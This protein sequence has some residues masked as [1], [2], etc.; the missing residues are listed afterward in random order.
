[1]KY[2]KTFD[3]R[4]VGAAMAFCVALAQPVRASGLNPTAEAAQKI[5]ASRQD[6]VLWITATCKV[7][8]SAEG[9][10]GPGNIPERE[11]RVETLGTVLGTNG[12][13][14]TSLTSIEPARGPGARQGGPGGGGRGRGGNARGRGNRPRFETTYTYRDVQIVM[15]DGQEIPAEVVMK[16]VDLDL[17]FIRAKTDGKGFSGAVFRGVD[18]KDDA[19][20]AMADDVITLARSDESFNREPAVASGRV[21]S[22]VLKPREFLH[23]SAV[24]LGVPFFNVEGKI[25][26][27][28][29]MRRVSGHGAMPVVVS[30]A[31]V[32]EIA[33]QAAVAR[34][35]AADKADAAVE[36]EKPS[37]AN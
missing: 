7:K 29:A 26:G 5:L 37:A 8:V 1:M 23:V 35:P 17:A 22:M 32:L 30:A 16:D 31:D 27:I 20:A 15:P 36:K 3:V 18:L 10:S 34:V 25:L 11:Q 19:K 12:M 6:S 14:V 2:P 33:E 13:L 28:G 21:I 24:G 9:G 4:A